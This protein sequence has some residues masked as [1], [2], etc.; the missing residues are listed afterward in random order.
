MSTA[1]PWI[2]DV[3]RKLQFQQDVLDSSSF[4]NYRLMVV[5]SRLVERMRATGNAVNSEAGESLIFEIGRAHV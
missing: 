4:D 2:D 5:R 1:Q 3:L